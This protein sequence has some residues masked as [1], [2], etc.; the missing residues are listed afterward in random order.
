MPLFEYL[1]VRCGNR[2][3]QL[4]RTQQPTPEIVC[5]RCKSGPVQKQMS[6]FAVAGGASRSATAA[7]SSAPAC[8]PG[9]G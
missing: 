9:G 6:G 4:V 7:A 1:C 2:F 5:P 8:A 3:E